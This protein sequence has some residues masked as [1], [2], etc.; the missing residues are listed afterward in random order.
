LI[1]FRRIPWLVHFCENEPAP[2]LENEHETGAYLLRRERNSGKGE[3]FMEYAQ[4]FLE[5]RNPNGEQWTFRMTKNQDQVTI[6]RAGSGPNDIQLG[7]NACEYISRRH[8]LLLK[9]DAKWWLIRKGKHYPLL[10]R[11]VGQVKREEVHEKVKLADGDLIRILGEISN[12]GDIYWELRFCDRETTQPVSMI[13]F[14]RY[15]KQQRALYRVVKGEEQLIPL[16][17]QE[18]NLVDFMLRQPGSLCQHEELIAVVWGNEQPGTRDELRHLI[19]RLR[20]KIELLATRRCFLISHPP[21]G[22]S[23]HTHPIDEKK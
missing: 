2:S 23:L 11:K 15:D 21:L 3:F 20:D 22:Y 8:C 4:Q 6:G 12:K 17:A 13:V 19:H 7:P 9:E 10:H 5:I 16:S 14:L 1:A 18:R